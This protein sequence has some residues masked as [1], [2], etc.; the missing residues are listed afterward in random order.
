MKS[1][2]PKDND[3]CEECYHKL[4]KWEMFKIMREYAQAWK[5][6]SRNYS[7]KLCFFMWGWVVSR[8]GWDKNFIKHMFVVLYRMKYGWTTCWISGELMVWWSKGVSIMGT[9]ASFNLQER[10]FWLGLIFYGFPSLAKCL[11][12][13]SFNCSVIC[14]LTLF[15]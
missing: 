5:G 8:V 2:I 12:F 7:E 9:G 1:W 15:G 10:W 14:Y 3:C 13:C 6:W 4:G 11:V